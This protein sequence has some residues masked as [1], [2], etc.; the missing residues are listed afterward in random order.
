MNTID[1]VQQT[2]KYLETVRFLMDE[3]QRAMMAI[4][5]N[6]LLD[7]EESLARQE[8]LTFQL[9]DLRR[10]LWGHNSRHPLITQPAI[11]RDLADDIVAA[12]SEL[13]KL[14]LVY[15]AVLQHCSHSASLMASLLGSLNGNFREASGPRLKH[16]TWSCQM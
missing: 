13:Y 6:G 12:H 14:N 7:L 5:R 1:R 16:Q 10:Q 2:K 11:D 3:L 9:T 15:E 4:S 8:I